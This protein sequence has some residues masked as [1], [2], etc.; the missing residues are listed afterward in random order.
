M[1]KSFSRI[2]VSLLTGGLAV[3][4]LAQ[5]AIA[6]VSVE[7]RITGGPSPN[8]VPVTINT[9]AGLSA[10]VT[11]TGVT[12]EQLAGHVTWTWEVTAKVPTN[13][14][15]TEPICT[16]NISHPNATS[17]VAS[18]TAQANF[19]GAGSW[20]V[21][22]K[23]TATYTDGEG[24]AWK[25]SGSVDVPFVAVLL[26]HFY[27]QHGENWVVI[28]D[29]E[30]F[31]VMKGT[32]VT[33]KA[34]KWPAEADWPGGKPV[35]GGSSGAAGGGETKLVAFNARS[36]NLTDYK[37]VT[38][39]C[40]N[41]V[42]L[43]VIVYEFAGTFTPNEVFEGR[44]MSKLGLREVAALGFT[45]TPNITA[46]QAG[47]LRWSIAGVGMFVA[48]S[49]EPDGTGTFYAMTVPG[50]GTVSLTVDSGPSKDSAHTYPVSVVQP[51]GGRCVRKGGVWHEQGKYA[52]GIMT[53][54]YLAPKDVSFRQLTFKE[55]DCP[56]VT[57]GWFDL[58][59]NQFKGFAHDASAQGWTWTA[60]GAG[61]A[62]NGCRVLFTDD[63]D[64]AA[65][66][67]T[68]QNPAYADGTFHWAI[69]WLYR[70]GEASAAQLIVNMPQHFTLTAEDGKCT[71]SK[72]SEASGETHINDPQSGY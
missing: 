13:P 38:S 16:T 40:G 46:A 48:G 4:L 11:V 22:C 29:T 25:G 24:Q 70:T 12:E 44:S 32:S 71:V 37:T 72:G 47:G 51:D 1:R 10:T 69:P 39:E 35:W 20:T 5:A 52:I 21:T 63:F 45:T 15:G 30:V 60:I 34:Q 17:P 55:G 33:F 62:Q 36:N 67:E 19:S 42:T 68:Q 3:L 28:N 9:T 53:D 41:T 66:W 58:E 6:Q 2:L 65:L 27:Y 18:L 64:Q 57:T 50:D 26:F 31:Y 59:G 8:P 23:A 49:P 61:N 14:F 54:F 7:A 56:A 43:N